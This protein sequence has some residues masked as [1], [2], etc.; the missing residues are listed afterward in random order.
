M[1][2]VLRATITT[3]GRRTTVGLA[4]LATHADE[5]VATRLEEPIGLV[6]TTTTVECL[7][8]ARKIGETL[9]LLPITTS[10]L[11]VSEDAEAPEA[12]AE[13]MSAPVA[14]G[15][16]AAKEVKDQTLEE[17]APPEAVI[18]TT[19]SVGAVPVLGTPKT[20]V[21]LA[22]GVRTRLR[23]GEALPP[24]SRKVRAIDGTKKGAQIFIRSMGRFELVNGGVTSDGGT[25]REEVL[26]AATFMLGSL[27]TVEEAGMR[28]SRAMIPTILS[29]AVQMF[30]STIAPG[31]LQ[32]CLFTAL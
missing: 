28:D 29:D 31:V 14:G 27:V 32:L 26:E 18:F 21:V 9:L 6:T 2:V 20:L 5:T 4:R 23:S 15:L 25:R 17:G 13:A 24:T 30:F 12:V 1:P 16:K 19:T 11:D 7:I 10:E 3:E 22:T 8:P